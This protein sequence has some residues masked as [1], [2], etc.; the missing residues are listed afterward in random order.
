MS[1]SLSLFPELTRNGYQE[2]GASS[3]VLVNIEYQHL[4]RGRADVF[5]K[6]LTASDVND[7]LVVTKGMATLMP[8]ANGS[9]IRVLDDRGD[10]YQFILSE[11]IGRTFLKPTF[12]P[13]A[14]KSFMKKR[15]AKTGDRI[16]F[17]PEVNEVKGTSYRIDFI[18]FI[19][20]VSPHSEGLG[21]SN[22]PAEFQ[23]DPSVLRAWAAHG[24]LKL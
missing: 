17:W 8:R 1:L 6:R 10:S 13:R 18:P 22:E 5:C 11:R 24:G 4:M 23:E 7:R 2:A 19:H 14:W 16:Y 12:Q 20:G 3:T 21:N 15:E 9:E